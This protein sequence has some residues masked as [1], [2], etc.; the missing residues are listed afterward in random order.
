M[1]LTFQHRWLSVR[2][3]FQSTASY[4]CLDSR[5]HSVNLRPLGLYSSFGWL[6]CCQMSCWP[7]LQPY[8]RYL[9]Q[10]PRQH[11]QWCLQQFPSTLC[12]QFW[13]LSTCSCTSAAMFPA[14][15]MSAWLV[16]YVLRKGGVWCLL[17]D[18]F[19]SLFLPDF[20]A[21]SLIIMHCGLIGPNNW[22]LQ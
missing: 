6:V 7:H 5:P 12:W 4:S 14:A 18:L 8:S 3:Q 17:M 2:S 20:L 19:L 9:I 1:T 15:Q 22:L 16:S 13:F 10:W 11:S 21:C